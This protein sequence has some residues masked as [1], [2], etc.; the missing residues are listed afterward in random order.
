MA[1]E[2]GSVAAAGTLLERGLRNLWYPIAPSWQLGENPLGVTRLGERIVVWRDREGTV[3]ALEDRCPH[4]GARLSLGWN[5]GDRL[6]CWYHGVEIDANGTV[7]DV[8]AVE[9]CPLTGRTAVRRYPCREVR[10]AIFAWF[11]DPLHEVPAEMDLPEQLVDDERFATM[12][13]VSTWQC[14]YRYAIDNVMDPMH[15]AYLHAR[16]HSM[17]KGN[18]R[19]RLRVVSTDTGFL[20][21]KEDQRNVNFDWVEFGATGG[22]WMRLAIPYGKAAGPGGPFGIVGFVTPVDRETCQVYFW[23]V[24][25]VEGWQRDLW[26]FLYRMRL[27]SL[28]WEVL[29]QDRLVLEAMA[30]DAREREFLYQ[31]DTGLARVRRFMANEAE[32]QVSALAG[33]DGRGGRSTGSESGSTEGAEA[34]RSARDDAPA[35]GYAGPPARKVPVRPGRNGEIAYNPWLAE[36]RGNKGDT[37]TLED[38]GSPLLLRWQHRARPPSE[39]EDRL[40]DALTAIFGDEVY[41]LPGIATQLNEAGVANPGSGPWT[42]DAFAAAMRELASP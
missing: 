18:R 35:S 26:R 42:E 11:G 3:H 27:E 20:C 29:E 30:G 28:H 8:P 33:T 14:N 22:H 31:H 10:G 36:P 19:A 24:R 6:A 5:L 37:E 39:H 17:A 25:R 41:D 23:R 2:T 34:N 38:L 9:S 16:S 1:D 40:A 12:L 7:L 21:E 4:R 32:R 15:G 13:C